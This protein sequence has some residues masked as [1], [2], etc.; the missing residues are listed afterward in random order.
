[1]LVGPVVGYGDVFTTPRHFRALALLVLVSPILP[2]FPVCFVL[3]I[4]LTV[5]VLIP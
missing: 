2:H 3:H 4:H 5:M 1:M